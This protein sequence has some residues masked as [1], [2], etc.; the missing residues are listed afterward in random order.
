MKLPFFKPKKLPVNETVD[1][2][3]PAPGERF[4]PSTM[5]AHTKTGEDDV[6]VVADVIAPGFR[7]GKQV[8]VKAEVQICT[9]D[10]W[11]LFD[12]SC[13]VARVLKARASDFVPGG[14]SWRATWGLTHPEDLRELLGE[15]AL[16]RWRARMIA[17]LNP[18]YAGQ[19]DRQLALTGQEGAAFE[20]STMQADG[21]VPAGDS[22]V[23][24]IVARNGIPQHGL[25]CPGG[26]PLLL[27]VVTV[28][29]EVRC[30]RTALL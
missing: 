19:P 9:I 24:G 11:V 30:A 1:T 14:T 8:A 6:W 18:A 28:D 7:V 10:Y 25:A 26:S 17:N 29:T 16:D 21:E 22:T 15:P 4:S 20:E 13:E 12:E 2:I 3:R 27:A 23:T 5:T